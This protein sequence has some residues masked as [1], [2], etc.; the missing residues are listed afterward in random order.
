MLRTTHTTA[1]LFSLT[2]IP[3]C[4][5]VLV[6]D[7]LDDDGFADT[8]ETGDGEGTD[9]ETGGDDA[10][11]GGGRG[12]FIGGSGD[13]DGGDGDGGDGD[14]GDGDGDGGDGDGDGDRGDGDG[15]HGDGDGGDGDGDNG[16][17]DSCSGDGDHGDSDGG[18]CQPHETDLIAAQHDDTGSVVIS[19]DDDRLSLSVEAAAPY[20]LSEVHVYVGTDPVP[21][22]GGGAVAPGQ[23]PYTQEFIDPQADYELELDLGDLGV[24]CG[25]SLEIAVHATIISIQDGALVYE[26]T[27]WGFGPEAFQKGWGWSFDYAICC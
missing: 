13:G 22:N 12:S 18:A 1:L 15:D 3:A 10:G 20:L 5:G 7:D 26:E 25:D 16:D 4:G 17:G 27:A 24:D 23:F 9:A 21:T 2:F 14:G 19:N 8:G 6:G 11:S